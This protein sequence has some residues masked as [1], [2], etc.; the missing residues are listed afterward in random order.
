MQGA[1][2]DQPDQIHASD[3]DLVERCL[4]RRP[5][6]WEELVRRYSAL[7]Y[8]IP[9]RL[10][11]SQ[12][13]AEDVAQSV[14][15]SLLTAMESMRDRQTL[16][17]W[18]ITVANRQ[19]WRSIRSRRN[20]PTPGGDTI[21]AAEQPD[22]ETPDIAAWERRQ[23]VREALVRLGGRCQELLT[24]LF[25]DQASPDYQEIG[26]R[27]GMP[28]GSIGPTRNRCLQKIMEVLRGMPGAAAIWADMAGSAGGSGDAGFTERVSGKGPG[29]T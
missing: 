26:R 5:G 8:S 21:D 23:T 19:A 18:L 16:A 14:F 4:D 6:A 7:V 28:I 25:S 2:L 29:A 12:D 27:L 9:R 24:A 10:G 22:D 3:A 11:L 1:S 20:S 15:A 13:E 17:K